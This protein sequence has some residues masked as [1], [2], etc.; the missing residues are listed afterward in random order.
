MRFSL[1]AAGFVV[2]LN[3]QSPT[4][5]RDT[6]TR[7]APKRVYLDA[8]A[9]PPRKAAP[10]QPESTP[11]A[12]APVIAAPAVV[13]APATPSVPMVDRVTTPS[14]PLRDVSVEQLARIEIGMTAGEVALALGPSASRVVIP[15]D[16]GHLIEHCQ[17]W[18]KGAW[19]GTVTLDNGRV[20]EVKGAKTKPAV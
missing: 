16:D 14:V 20:V 5:Q 11:A 17:Y 6:R 9:A 8:P 12:K 13:T 4:W 3:A 10:E 2:V 18:S 7:L 15:D 19:A 1:L